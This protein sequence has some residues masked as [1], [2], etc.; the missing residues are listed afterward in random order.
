MQPIITRR[1]PG[2]NNG[3]ASLRIR[4]RWLWASAAMLLIGLGFAPGRAALARPLTQDTDPSQVTGIALSET[5]PLDMCV[6]NS[7]GF[8]VAVSGSARVIRNGKPVEVQ[9][10]I[11][12]V[13]VNA[14]VMNA[15]LGA[16]TPTTQTT[17]LRHGQSSLDPY[18]H[19]TFLFTARKAGATSLY[20][21]VPGSATRAG[22]VQVRIDDCEPKLLSLLDA[23]IQGARYHG[24]LGPVTLQVGD[25]GSLSGTGPLQW[26]EVARDPE[27]S[28]LWSVPGLLATQA[29]ITGS[30]SDTSID[31]TVAF[32]SYSH[33]VCGVCD[34]GSVCIDGGDDFGEIS[35]SFPASGGAIMTQSAGYF[36]VILERQAP[37]A[38]VSA[39]PEGGR[40]V[41]SARAGFASQGGSQ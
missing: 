36:T 37:E 21:E 7:H 28:A 30:M 6:G 19:A 24:A 17:A 9:R 23:E 29:A 40:A 34:G 38:A 32:Q 8:T 20:F 13:R 16:F 25:D 12:G 3:S 2:T 33:G 15:S 22:P 10:R 35:V 26:T 18:S 1:Q 31:V 39:V 41:A 11:S 27:C 4:A 14:V 5:G